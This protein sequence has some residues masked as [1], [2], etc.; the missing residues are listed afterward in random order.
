MIQEILDEVLD[1]S[2]QPDVNPRYT[3]KDNVGNV[4]NDNVQIELKTSVVTEGTPLNRA[5]FANLQGDLY[6]QDRYN[7]PV[8]TSEN[9][10][11]INNLSLP[12][13]SYEVGKIIR[14]KAQKFEGNV[15]SNVFAKNWIKESTSKYIAGDGSTITSNVMQE[16]G[17]NLSQLF[18]LESGE[19]NMCLFKNF[20]TLKLELNLAKAIKINKMAI[21]AFGSAQSM[22]IKA[23][24]NDSWKTL[25]T[26][27]GSSLPIAI[28]PEDVIEIESPEYSSRYLIEVT[29]GTASSTSIYIS[30]WQTIEYETKETS[31]SNPYININNLG[32]IP[33]KGTIYA[34][35]YYNLVFDGIQYLTETTTIDVS[36]STILAT[37][38]GTYEL[39]PDITYDVV[40]IG[41]G[42]GTW[43]D[44]D[45]CAAYGGGS[46]GYVTGTISGIS[47]IDVIIG[48]GGEN[49]VGYRN[50]N[51]DAEDGGTTI[52]GDLIAY[53]GTG[54]ESLGPAGTGGSYSGGQGQDGTSGNSIGSTG[55]GYV[56][57]STPTGWNLN[58]TKGGMYG[59]GGQT[60]SKGGYNGGYTVYHGQD[61]V[62]AFIPRV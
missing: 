16:D 8:V 15:Q 45:D 17:R 33:I 21:Y 34:N 24:T 40:A 4:I 10:N 59:A 19:E 20:S 61:G 29:K 6:T 46:G 48:A 47:S 49:V 60:Y 23:Y 25:L 39:N 36:N 43:L 14:M 52:V 57:G 9:G 50:W 26:V 18:N 28:N 55:S 7:A 11:F 38:S 58:G 37:T 54:A 56:N 3:L 53:G 13:T 44:T 35:N 42:G 62:V 51:W 22:T 12:L 41:G 30:H 32:A 1:T 27:D 31:F 5:T 2:L